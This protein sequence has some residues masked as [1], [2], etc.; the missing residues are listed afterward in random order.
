VFPD[1]FED[2][3]GFDAVLGNPPFLGGNK[4]SGELGRDY[5]DHLIST[6]ASG[7]RTIVD[8]AVYCWARMHQ[9]ASPYG[10]IGIVGPHA[11]LKGTN[12]KLASVLL[13]RDGWRPYRLTGTLSWPGRTAAVSVCAVWT[14]Q[15]SGA[16][17]PD[18]IRDVPELAPPPHLWQLSRTIEAEG[19]AIGVWVPITTQQKPAQL[20]TFSNLPSRTASPQ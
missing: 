4:V 6:T 13:D 2:R 12:F 10:V 1:V 17:P 5:R 20:A 16:D 7:K 19:H 3:G 15:C 11:L 9:L 8:L 14:H 18:E